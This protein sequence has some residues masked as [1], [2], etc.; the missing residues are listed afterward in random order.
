[1]QRLERIDG[2]LPDAVPPSL[3]DA[4][5]FAEGLRYDISEERELRPLQIRRKIARETISTIHVLVI[6]RVDPG[7]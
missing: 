2:G 6:G 1:V 4:R 3:E 7:M 5:P